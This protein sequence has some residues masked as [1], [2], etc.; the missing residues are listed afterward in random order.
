M[1]KRNIEKDIFRKD[2]LKRLKRASKNAKK[3]KD[4]GVGE[5]LNFLMKKFSARSALVFLPLPIEPNLTSFIKKHRKK[6]D[7]FVPIMEGVS[8]KAVEYRLP[9]YKKKFNIKEP[10]N[11]F[12]KFFKID[13]AIVPVVGVDGDF[14]RIGFGKGMYD[15]F[16]EK[17]GYRPIIV[18]VQIDKCYT[19]K[20]VSDT[21]DIYAD[22]YITPTNIFKKR[23]KKDANGSYDRGSM[24]RCGRRG[25]IYNIS[26]NGCRKI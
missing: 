22:F 26:K 20:I 14:R 11:S 8:F 3:Y 12:F 15:R 13:I 17:L 7:V 24:R 18:F 21:Y 19:D 5:K 25:R 23:G 6:I 16:F 1:L 10:K 4:K 2:C 9:V